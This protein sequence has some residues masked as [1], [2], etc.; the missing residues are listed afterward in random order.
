MKKLISMLICLSMVLSMVALPVYA[1]DEASKASTPTQQSMLYYAADGSISVGSAYS[2]MENLW[3]KFAYNGANKLMQIRGFY[4]DGK[5]VE[6]PATLWYASDSDFVG[7]MAFEVDSAES[8]GATWTGGNHAFSDGSLS[9]MTESVVVKLDGVVQTKPEEGATTVT[10]K[11]NIVEITVVNKIKAGNNPTGDY[12]LK[13]T[14]VYTVYDN[15]I[16]VNVEL[17]ALEN[18]KIYSYMGLQHCKTKSVYNKSI[19]FTDGTN[20]YSIAGTDYYPYRSGPKSSAGSV[21]QIVHTSTS[22]DKMTMTLDRSYCLGQLTYLDET[23]DVANVSKMDKT[24]FHLIGPD[25]EYCVTMAK[26]GKAGWKGQYKYEYEQKAATNLP[27]CLWNSDADGDGAF[28]SAKIADFS[29][30]TGKEARF[31]EFT[32]EDGNLKMKATKT[33]GSYVEINIGED[34]ITDSDA[35]KFVVECDVNIDNCGANPTFQMGVNGVTKLGGAYGSAVSGKFYLI[36]DK[37]TAKMKMWRLDAATKAITQMTNTAGDLTAVPVTAA[38]NPFAVN[39][40]LYDK[41]AG[42]NTINY[43][44]IYPL[45]DS[46][47]SEITD[48]SAT[49]AVLKTNMPIDINKTALKIGN[50]LVDVTD[51]DA[52]NTYILTYE[53]DLAAGEHT[54][55]GTVS[56]LAYDA[57]INVSNKFNVEEAEKTFTPATELYFD[58]FD[59]AKATED[60]VAS[61]NSSWSNQTYYKGVFERTDGKLKIT[62]GGSKNYVYFGIPADKI[63]DSNAKKFVVEWDIDIETAAPRNVILVNGAAHVGNIN[64]DTKS[65]ELAEGKHYAII[66]ST[67]SKVY[68]YYPG[69]AEP[70]EGSTGTVTGSALTVDFGCTVFSGGYNLY[71]YIAIYPFESTL[72]AKA[73]EID[74]S[75][76]TLKTNMPLD[77]S[78]STVTVDGAAAT[79]TK[80]DNTYNEY[81]VTFASAVALGEHTMAVSAVPVGETT[82]QT[83]ELKFTV[84]TAAPEAPKAG[85]FDDFSSVP[86][87]EYFEKG[88]NT[89]R[90]QTMTRDFGKLKFTKKEGTTGAFA[91]FILPA[92][93]IKSALSDADKFVIEYD[94]SFTGEK[95]ASYMKI[96]NSSWIGFYSTPEVVPGKYYAIYDRVNN[97]V[98]FYYPGC[99]EPQVVTNIPAATS[100]DGF[101]VFFTT[102]CLN[103]YAAYDYIA[104]Y[105]LEESLE[106]EV[107]NATEKSALLSTNIPVDLTS[108]FTV[109]G[110]ACTIEEL[111]NAYNKYV[112]TPSTPFVAG[113]EYTAAA[114][115]VKSIEGT[116]LVTEE[117]SS[118]EAEKGVTEV[119]SIQVAAGTTENKIALVSG[120]NNVVGNKPVIIISQYQ[121]AGGSN[122]FTVLESEYVMLPFD[123]AFTGFSGGPSLSAV[124]EEGVTYSYKAFIWE[125]MENMKPLN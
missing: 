59:N 22:G 51:G 23:T 25:K 109:N 9:A 43:I 21:N 107:S 78:K 113:E 74:A 36:Y 98:S 72:S 60:F 103:G 1:A 118:F 94:L 97:T 2:E 45:V 125:N 115:N 3:I 84:N 17:E 61:S 91:E 10:K 96:N 16:D 4:R 69:G 106:F 77:L 119:T 55:S 7:P 49:S 102:T 86:E 15:K 34:K 14:V 89:N 79:V 80:N 76:A 90:E 87:E 29:A 122:V 19:V 65:K 56:A 50:N 71:D 41:N 116:S 12:A 95:P 73:E 75:A 52:Y 30:T 117:T 5:N 111:D 99:T 20:E 27:I 81:T 68:Y 18:L 42:Y 32:I 105:P 47:Y 66:D 67:T 13:E 124:E 24:Y 57:D 33:T 83:S 88:T 39:F 8:I 54:L 44:A 104:V 53:D 63:V 110:A 101:E 93:K 120:T 64:S 6:V 38:G 121:S 40:L 28:D 58:N 82:A 85:F 108:V 100:A 31:P 114:S 70:I 48:V 112:L 26:G 46:F 37:T 35:T 123:G 11:G 62:K 92:S